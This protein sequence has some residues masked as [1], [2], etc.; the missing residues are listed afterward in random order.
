MGTTTLSFSSVACSE[1]F[2]K[3]LERSQR[4]ENNGYLDVKA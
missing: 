4:I 2:E 1:D 3:E